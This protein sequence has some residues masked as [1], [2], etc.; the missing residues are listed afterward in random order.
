MKLRSMM[1]FRKRLVI[2]TIE[3][4]TYQDAR[5][6]MDLLYCGTTIKF[7]YGIYYETY[8]TKPSQEEVF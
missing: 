1:E 4:Q 6:N 5:F 2:H 8:Y 3:I 7:L